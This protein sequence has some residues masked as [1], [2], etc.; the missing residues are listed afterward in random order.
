MLGDALKF[1]RLFSFINHNTNMDFKIGHITLVFLL[2][3]QLP[4]TK[5]H[6][7]ESWNLSILFQTDQITSQ[8]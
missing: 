6:L 8:Y 3:Q 4:Q 7:V 5:G 2:S 1:K